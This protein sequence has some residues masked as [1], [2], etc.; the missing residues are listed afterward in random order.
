MAGNWT[1]QDYFNI[2]PGLQ[3]GMQ[4]RGQ[5]ENREALT[6]REAADA[7]DR[8]MRQADAVARMGV[9]PVMGPQGGIDWQATGQAA[10]QRQKITRAAE[11]MGVMHA[12]GAGPSGAMTEEE[13]V[14]TQT[15]EY[16]NAFRAASAVR[17]QQEAKAAAELEQIGA[18]ESAELAIA[19]AKGENVSPPRATVTT[20]LPDGTTVRIPMSPEEAAAFQ[21][22][23]GA[24]AGGGARKVDRIQEAI[25]AVA[26]FQSS[27]TAIDVEVDEQGF[28]KVTKS[29]AFHD[30]SPK[31]PRS[32]DDVIQKILRMRPGGAP[33]QE[34]QRSPGGGRGT[35]SPMISIP[36]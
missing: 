34:V 28:P 2:W 6:R 5:R 18:R 36:R 17:A 4:M 21:P 8:Q 9:P 11:A 13:V 27:G 10:I 29:R 19:K 32:Y 23:A 22:A 7:E 26:R 20:K 12:W 3:A 35:N 14:I 15:P 1:T 25:D 31:N 24:G 30:A 16:Q 33:A